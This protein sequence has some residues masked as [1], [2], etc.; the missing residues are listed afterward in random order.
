[1]R[2][3]EERPPRHP[4]TAYSC[5]GPRADGRG[6]HGAERRRLRAR[7]P[8]QRATHRNGYRDRRW[9]TRVGTVQLRIPRVDTLRGSLY[10][11]RC[12]L[13]RFVN[14]PIRAVAG[15]EPRF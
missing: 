6:R 11:D 14:G 12:H 2:L 10:R 3:Q 9:D 7:N 4:R 8:D 5:A 15:C 1:M 13:N